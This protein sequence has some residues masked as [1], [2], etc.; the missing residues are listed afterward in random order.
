MLC[1]ESKTSEPKTHIVLL[2]LSAALSASNACLT[3][4]RLP[5]LTL[6]ATSSS[7]LTKLSPTLQCSQ[8]AV[9]STQRPP[10]L[11]LLVVDQLRADALGCYA[12]SGA[13]AV[14]TPHVDALA[15][16]GTVFDAAYSS[17]PTCTPARSAL[18]TGRSPWGHGL[19]G[20]VGVQLFHLEDLLR[21][22]LR[23]GV[24]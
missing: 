10:H 17:T 2:V 12:T 14:R 7:T 4:W 3:S 6:I 5:T 19:L 11:L 18:L 22:E 20:C 1:P 23:A 8:D 13:S 21:K 16:A 15:A 9:V 24:V